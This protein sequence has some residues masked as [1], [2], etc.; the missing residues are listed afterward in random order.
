MTA[1]AKTLRAHSPHLTPIENAFYD[2]YE[3]IYRKIRHSVI[4]DGFSR[5]ALRAAYKAGH[6][7]ASALKR[8]RT[9][10]R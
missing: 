4:E 3:R 9:G 2:W 7:H 10:R 1:S 8:K 6:R 5:A